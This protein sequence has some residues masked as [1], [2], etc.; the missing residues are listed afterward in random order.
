MAY[1]IHITATFFPVYPFHMPLHG[2]FVNSLLKS[3]RP[4]VSLIHLHSPLTPSIKTSV[5]IVLTIHTP[6][7]IDA[8]HYEVVDPQFIC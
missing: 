6:M 3:L 4:E 2:L 5:P 8:M 7:R 1:T